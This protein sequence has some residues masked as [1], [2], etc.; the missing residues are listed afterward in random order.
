MAPQV[1]SLLS[2][3]AAAV[4]KQ[5]AL[6]ETQDTIIAILDLFFNSYPLLS[7]LTDINYLRNLSVRSGQ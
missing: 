7:P 4:H 3:G 2:A 6:L 1:K 5:K